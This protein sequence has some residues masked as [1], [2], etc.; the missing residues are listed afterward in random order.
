MVGR[1]GLTRERALSAQGITWP[2][3]RK[4]QEDALIANWRHGNAALDPVR[5]KRNLLKPLLNTPEDATYA[6]ASRSQE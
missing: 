5:I 3:V 4:P 2:S 1:F 6:L